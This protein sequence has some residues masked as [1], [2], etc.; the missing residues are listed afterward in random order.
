MPEQFEAAPEFGPVSD[1]R[2]PWTAAYDAQAYVELMTTQSDHR[3]LPPDTL[4][5]LHAGIAAAI[6]DRGDR[7]EIPYETRL[8]LA[9]RAG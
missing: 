4:A 8:L 6:R 1:H 3:L 5:D 9:R 2:F 7:I